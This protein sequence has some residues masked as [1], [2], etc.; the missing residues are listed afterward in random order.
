MP[1]TSLGY[2]GLRFLYSLMYAALAA[3]HSL[4]LQWRYEDR[5]PCVPALGLCP[6]SMTVF[7]KWHGEQSS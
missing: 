5:V 3:L 2:R 1:P 6:R 7:A 4:H